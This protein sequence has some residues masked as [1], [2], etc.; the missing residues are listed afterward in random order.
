[1]SHDSG[2]KPAGSGDAAVVTATGL[3]RVLTDRDPAGAVDIQQSDAVM[4]R[5][6]RSLFARAIVPTWTH[7]V[8]PAIDAALLGRFY[9]RFADQAVTVARRVHYTVTGTYPA[10]RTPPTGAG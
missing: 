10:D 4:D 9:E 6:D 8:E 7:D 1:M 2:P 5:L 3:A